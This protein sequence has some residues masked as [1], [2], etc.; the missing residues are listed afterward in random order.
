MGFKGGSNFDSGMVP[1]SGS[2]AG[3]GSYV[4]F[5]ADD[6]FVL[7]TVEASTVTIANDSDNRVI[8]A[9]GDGTLNA[10]IAL[11]FDGSTFT[12]GTD[13]SLGHPD[14]GNTLAINAATIELA[15]VA[16][17]TDNTV[18]VYDGSSIVTDEIDS[19]VWDGNLIDVTGTPADNQLATWADADTVQGESNLTFDGSTLAVTG[20]VSASA[21]ITGSVLY[22]AGSIATSGSVTVN[23]SDDT[24]LLDI[25][26]TSD[27]NILNV[28]DSSG[29]G[30][31]GFGTAAP[32]V[33]WKNYEFAG[34]IYLNNGSFFFDNDKGFRWGDSSVLV[35]GNAN[36]ETLEIRA[37]S[38]S[39]FFLTGSST[40][41]EGGKIGVGTLTPNSTLNI[42]GSLATNVVSFTSDINMDTTHYTLVGNCN[43]G[44]LTSS[45]PAATDVL[46]GRTYVVKRADSPT[47]GANPLIVDRNAALIDGAA[48]NLS[49]ANGDCYT[50]QCVGASSGWIILTKYIAV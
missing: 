26:S 3:P 42:S 43:A 15:N 30:K 1:E 38:T 48:S 14:G 45:L 7:T 8:T 20:E 27:S 28:I 39:Y 29:T 24:T 40:P 12:A 47:P 31:I 33:G 41:G 22:V 46:V 50:L 9:V 25:N 36:D 19:K 21:G 11:T 23:G 18:L 17:G 10:E 13:A 5:N 6:E 44:G 4:G 16:A 34:P 2:I 32:T 35:E 37:N 49:L